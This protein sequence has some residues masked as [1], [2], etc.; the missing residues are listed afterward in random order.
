M[1]AY[2]E[3]EVPCAV[4]CNSQWYGESLSQSLSSPGRVSVVK[5]VAA[6]AGTT[7]TAAAATAGAAVAFAAAI[8]AAAAGVAFTGT[9][10]A[11]AGAAVALAVATAGICW[12]PTGGP[13]YGIVA[14]PAASGAAA[15][16]FVAAV[17]GN[18]SCTPVS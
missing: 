12:G 17:A 2:K 11:F 1:Q 16:A 10:V 18:P 5:L 13:R 14:F 9:A 6:E 8:G 3:L 7:G 4:M 15:V